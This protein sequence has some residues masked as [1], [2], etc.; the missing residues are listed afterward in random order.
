MKS[1]YPDI[2]W[3]RTQPS[4]VTTASDKTVSHPASSRRI[5]MILPAPDR[6]EVV[7]TLARLQ[8]VAT[9]REA[10]ER[11]LARLSD[12]TS[13]AVLNQI[14]SELRKT[15][16]DLLDLADAQRCGPWPTYLEP[17]PI[18]VEPS[19]RHTNHNP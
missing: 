7:A 4:R 11:A 2:A 17:P 8:T 5:S 19:I 1:P 6:P 15:E 16:K 13:R 14:I 3:Q 10:I 9:V 12:P 18:P